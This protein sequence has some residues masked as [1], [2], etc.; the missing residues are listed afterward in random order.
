MQSGR[1]GAMA[2]GRDSQVLAP[3][4]VGGDLTNEAAGPLDVRGWGWGERTSTWT[5]VTAGA[6]LAALAGVC[7]VIW[8]GSGATLWLAGAAVLV[9]AAG[10]ATGLVAWRP[11]HRAPG[12][13]LLLLGGTLGL[14][15]SWYAVTG[16]TARLAT[17]GLTVA[18]VFA[19]LG[20]CTP[21]GRGG[22]T[23]AASIALA[24]GAWELGLALTTPART[25]VALGFVSV[26]VLGYLP[27]YALTTAGLT[28]LDD[29][30][31]GGTPVSRHQVAAALGATHRGLALATVAMA[32][33]AGAAGVL[34]VD[35]PGLW[36]VLAALL[37]CVVL[38]SRARAYPL[39]VEVVALL[40]AG[41]AVC[42][43]LVL[44]WAT[45]DGAGP[46]GALV[47]LGVLAAL[48]VAMLAV[49]VPEPLRARLRRWL[50][51]VESAGVVALIPVA[52]GAFG[53]Y[54]LLL[55]TS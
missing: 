25:G 42:V 28:R 22:L 13:A 43:R 52:L 55:G 51:L 9:A 45:A 49:R 3:D 26:L 23:G 48:P 27:R 46:A 1:D 50:D 16:G 6:L 19:L 10:A 34:A 18:A 47:L 31:S 4:P 41:T 12:V 17:V 38:L 7:A 39:A 36:T 29:R 33:S 54:T 2:R 11:G 37:L 8:Y 44:L 5:A 14:V 30:R 40:A 20:L 32:A 35:T 24:V 53:G 15:A 21:L